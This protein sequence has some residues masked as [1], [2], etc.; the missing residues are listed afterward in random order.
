MALS[1]CNKILAVSLVAAL[2][3]GCALGG[4]AP[5]EAGAE[6]DSP[7]QSKAEQSDLSKAQRTAFKQ[8][9]AALE[10]GNADKAATIFRQLT[11]AKPGLAAAHANLGTALMM[12]GDDVLAASSLKRATA[13]DADLAE[14]Q[15]RLGVLHRR[16][17]DFQ[18][19]EAAYR[20]ALDQQP[21][22]RYAHLNLGILYD[23]YLQQPQQALTQYKHFQKLSAEPDQDVAKWIT[24]LKSRL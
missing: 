6:G 3:G 18:K 23:V 4:S 17:G 9:A 2:L 16:Q 15:V 5:P 7:T 22:N 8:G 11:K 20:T 1:A 13:L 12:R 14:A 19:A 21:D 10:A 24:D